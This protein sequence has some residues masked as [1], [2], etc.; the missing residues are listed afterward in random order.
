MLFLGRYVN[1]SDNSLCSRDHIP[2]MVLGE[3]RRS[4]LENE[5]QVLQPSFRG[6][7]RSHVREALFVKRISSGEL[8]I[9]H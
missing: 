1:T 8:I 7:W 3:P 6:A 2:D 4:T 9:Q 5:Y